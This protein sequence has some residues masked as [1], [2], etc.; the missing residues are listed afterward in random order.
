MNACKENEVARDVVDAAYQIHREIFPV[1][2]GV[3]RVV[4]GLEE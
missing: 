2:D 1:K 4:N 3:K